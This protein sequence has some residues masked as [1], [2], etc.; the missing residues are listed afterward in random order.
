MDAFS[1]GLENLLD[2]DG[3]ILVVHE[4]SAH[5]AKF[6]V[7][8]VAPSPARP[9]GIRYSLTLH[10]RNN[11]RVLG[12]DNAHGVPKRN[13]PFDHRHRVPG[14][15]GVPYDFKSPE[16]LLIDFW[17]DVDRILKHYDQQ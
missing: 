5:W 10:D 6:E 3:E 8:R 7:K 4:I 17:T 1:K 2:L 9:H 15:M 16:K 14:D 11:R 13:L 12:Y